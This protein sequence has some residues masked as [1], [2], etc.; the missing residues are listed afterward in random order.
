MILGSDGSA[1]LY[2]NALAQRQ[3]NAI[4]R[5]MLLTAA[6]KPLKHMGQI[7]IRYP[8][9]GVGNDNLRKKRGL[10]QA[11]PRCGPLPACAPEHFLITFCTASSVQV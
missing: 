9:P 11:D 8:L 1:L 7:L 3:T 5:S 6:V 4:S 10:P 2:D